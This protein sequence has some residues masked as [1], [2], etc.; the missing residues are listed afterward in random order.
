MKIQIGFEEQDRPVV[1]RLY[2]SAFQR[3]FVDLIGEK[4]VVARLLE[5]GLIPDYSLICYDQGQVVGLAGFHVGKKSFVNL[6][7]SHFIQQFG[8]FKGLWKGIWSCI[9]FYR[10]PAPKGELPM[11]GIAVDENFQGKGIGNQ[12]LDALFA[13][14]KS[15]DYEAIHLD[16]IDENPRAK[17]LYQKLNFIEISHEKFPPFIERLIGASGITH[18]R[19]SL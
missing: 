19:K 13:W 18:M 1:A 12:L 5:K 14:A 6:R 11:N 2:A 7:L 3:K 4:E 17:K 10:K 8:F 16:V 9:I 15:H